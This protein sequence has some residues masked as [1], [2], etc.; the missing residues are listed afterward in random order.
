[1][2]YANPSGFD[3]GPENWDGYGIS[4]IVFTLIFTTLL[5]SACFFLFMYRNHPVVK[6]RNVPLMLSSVIVLHVFFGMSFVVYTLNGRWPCQVEFWCMNLYFPI[7]IGLFQAQ[8]QQLLIVSQGQAQLAAQDKFYKPIPAPRGQGVG[9]VRYWIFRLKFWWNRIGKHERYLALVYVGIVVQVS[10]CN[11]IL[12]ALMDADCW[13]LKFIVSFI[14]YN[15]SRKF[16]H[17][18]VVDHH[19]GPGLCRRGW[20]W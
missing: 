3:F 15:I 18:G 14:I 9:S 19:V 7:G 11:S 10:Y 4:M 20:E 8:N 6:M 12:G 17:Y 16:N 13:S 1:M 5:F 2:V